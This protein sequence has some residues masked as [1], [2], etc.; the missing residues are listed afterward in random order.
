[1]SDH[2]NLLGIGQTE[3]ADSARIYVDWITVRKWCIVA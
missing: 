2:T 3:S 1:M